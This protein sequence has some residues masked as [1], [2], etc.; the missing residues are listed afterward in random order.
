LKE[1]NRAY[2]VLKDERARGSY[3]SD[4]EMGMAS[5]PDWQEVS[6]MK[7]KNFRLAWGLLILPALGFC[8]FF[9]RVGAHSSDYPTANT[10]PSTKPQNAVERAELPPLRAGQVSPRFAN[11]AQV[12]P[13][14]EGF[15]SKYFRLHAR[16]TSA[17]NE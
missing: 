17:K 11:R 12:V 5:Q 9:W 7:Q 3:D 10:R 15:F 1:L 4:V 14:G 2:D 13:P 6:K 16:P 8:V